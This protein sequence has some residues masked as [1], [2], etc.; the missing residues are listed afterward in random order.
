MSAAPT[1]EPSTATSVTTATATATA[2]DPVLT[3]RQLFG[4]LR[5][6]AAAD[7]ENAS[8][9]VAS[10]D[11]LR[12]SGLM[13]L[14]VPVEYGGLGGSLADLAAVAQELGRG[15]LSTALIWA[16]H[17]QQVATLAEYAGPALRSRLLPR[18]ARGEVYVASVTSE[19]GKGGHLTSAAAALGREDGDLLIDRDAPIV[20]GG[21][22]ADGFL[23]TMRDSADASANAVTLVY[24]D[25]EQLET[26]QRDGWNPMG[27]RATHSVAMTLR[28][29]VPADQRVGAAGGFAEASAAVFAPAAHIGW[30][31]SWLGAVCGVLRDA[32]TT[33]REPS[34]RRDFDLRSELVL[35]R[36]ARIRLDVDAVDA[37]LAQVVREIEEIRRTGGDIGAAPVQLRLNGLKVFA[38]ETLMSA[39]DRLMDLLGLRHGYMR[40]SAIPAERLFRDLK[41]ARLNYSN[42]RLTTANGTL[43]LFD[44]EVS[45]G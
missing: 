2:A 40:G 11:A 34:G 19:K 12:A 37:F 26:T 33:L 4:V 39:A 24:A 29:T 15:S 8:F 23:I 22:Q 44:P 17:C 16:M 3:A 18:I 20:T 32:L 1:R 41:S 5:E 42:D 25:R 35:D 27:M 21:A 9:P 6:N 30:S 13:G 28:G 7:D 38:S 36:I 10:L 14:S 31:A 45:L 43:A